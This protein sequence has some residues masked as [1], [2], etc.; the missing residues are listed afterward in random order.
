MSLNRIS[1]IKDGWIDLIVSS[2]TNA[3]AH[4]FV[5]INKM[6]PF[7]EKMCPLLKK[8]LL[9][10]EYLISHH[11]SWDQGNHFA[12]RQKTSSKSNWMKRTVCHSLGLYVFAC[13][14]KEL[15]NQFPSF[16]SFAC[17]KGRDESGCRMVENM[18]A[19]LSRSHINTRIPTNQW[20]SWG[21]VQFPT[22]VS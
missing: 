9:L 10:G 19:Q 17:C 11:C 3:L 12:R 21:A 20:R 18:N 22:K 13:S 16:F 2:S 7:S 14:K 5:F 15:Q 1:T 6:W 8:K 4:L